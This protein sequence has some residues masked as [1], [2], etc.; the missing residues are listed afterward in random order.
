MPTG[1]TFKLMEK[2]Q[3]FED[4][5]MGCARAMGACV[6][7]RDDPDDKPIPEKFEPSSF[8]AESLEKELR[9]LAYLEALDDEGRD[10]WGRARKA[11][12]IQSVRE[13]ILRERAQNARLYEICA[14]VQAWT[15]PTPDHE[16]LKKFMLD[17]LDLS[18]IDVSYSELR[19]QDAV[20]KS[21]Q[22][23][24]DEALKD[25]RRSSA[26][27]EREVEAERQRASN[28]TDW[29]SKLRQSIKGRD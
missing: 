22:E 6:T 15:P 29:I 1:Y 9:A 20:A 13:S 14:K 17:Q 27:Y 11:T 19:A 8:Y 18:A 25:H 21:P 10:R 2:G 3:S 23:Y 5:V 4:F 16:G 28:R 26:S 7:M 12:E 24:F